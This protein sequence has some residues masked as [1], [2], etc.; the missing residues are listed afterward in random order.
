MGLYAAARCKRCNLLDQ[1]HGRRS[2]GVAGQ[3]HKQPTAVLFFIFLVQNIRRRMYSRSHPRFLRAVKVLEKSH[4]KGRNTA[5]EA[6]F[7]DLR[8]S[9]RAAS[10]VSSCSSGVGTLS[11]SRRV[12]RRPP[13]RDDFSPHCSISV[14]ERLSA[15]VLTGWAAGAADFSIR[16]HNLLPSWQNHQAEKCSG[17]TR[18]GILQRPPRQWWQ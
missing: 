18:R 2:G 11:W 10:A 13:A 5:G 12:R 6:T 9:S 15:A 7:T 8:N 17:Q 4:W 1:P 3:P 16:P 14:N